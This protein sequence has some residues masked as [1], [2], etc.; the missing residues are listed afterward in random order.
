M[1]IGPVGSPLPPLSTPAFAFETLRSLGGVAVSI[2]LLSIAQAISIARAIATRSGQRIDANQELI[3]QGLS[4]L[5]ASFFSGYPSS[6]SLN[7]SG[8]NFEAGARTPLAAVLSAAFLAVLLFVIAPL[9]A[10]IPAAVVAAM[11]MLIGWTLIDFAAIRKIVRMSR[12]ETFV[13]AVTFLAT[14][15][16]SM[17]VAILVGV[18]VSL[19]AYLYRTSRPTMHSLVPDPLDP[20]RRMVEAH[21][22]LRECPQLKILRIEGSIYFGAT[23]HVATHFDTLRKVS[24]VQKHLLLLAQSINFVDVSGADLLA[25]EAAI[26]RAQGGDL[27]LHRPRQPAREM[28]YRGGQ[29]DRIGPGHVFVSMHEAIATVFARLDE[30]RCRRCTAR[31][32]RECATVAPADTGLEAA[33]PA[34]DADAR[35]R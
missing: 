5:A 14:M 24:P 8:A 34:R 35:L 2:T 3:G 23:H 32:F 27:Y 12:P 9:I 20:E 6:A 1:S 10:F 26:R 13:L 22:P 18:F 21:E 15:T 25:E 7:R 30:G 29:L 16:L 17:E 33:R 4:N 31:I 11:L 28:L 19:V